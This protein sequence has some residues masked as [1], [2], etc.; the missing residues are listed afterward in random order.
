M[1]D[2]CV[3]CHAL[4]DQQVGL[5]QALA[6]SPYQ[7]KRCLWILNEET[8]KF[9]ATQTVKGS[10]SYRR[11][12]GRALASIK[13]GHFTEEIAGF[14]LRECDLIRVSIAHPD[15]YPAG[16][17]NVECIA[18]LTLQENSVARFVRHIDHQP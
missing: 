16:V 10:V 17:D 8:F 12:I 13:H 1:N 11:G 4:G 6:D 18:R 7:F 14:K 2:V 9:F 3:T 5:P 15:A